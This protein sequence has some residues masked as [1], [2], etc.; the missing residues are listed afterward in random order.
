LSITT[1][2]HDIFG[3]ITYNRDD[4][5]WVGWCTLPVFAQYGRITPDDYRLSEPPPEFDRGAFAIS[6]QDASGNGPSVEEANV[7]HFLRER[8]TEVCRA[9]MTELINACDMRGGLLR[10]LNERRESPLWGWLARLC[11]PEYKVPEDLKQAVRCRS[12]EISS[13][14]DGGYSY[15]A[16]SF[17]TIFGFDAEHGLAV[18]FH[19]Q[20]G[21]FCGDSLAI[22]DV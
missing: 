22:H 6:V 5:A 10:W 14:S 20:N 2:H 13:Q 3:D 11:G 1:I 4:L 7:F 15:I 16:F 12:V 17:E 21:T 18:V 19:P 9:V 8:E